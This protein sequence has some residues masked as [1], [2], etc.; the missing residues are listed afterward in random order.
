MS[1]PADDPRMALARTAMVEEQIAARGVRDPR[2]L[3]ALRQV[4][5][6]RF[7]PGELLLQA[8]GDYPLPIGRGQTISQP[9]I[10]AFMA[11]ALALKGHERVLE[12]GSG[13]G[14]MTAVLSRLCREVHGIELE[15]EL[16]EASRLRLDDLGCEN[17]QLHAG[18][19]A[20]GWPPA[21]PFDAIL[22]SC[23]TPEIPAPLWEQ[24]AEGGSLLLPL[25]S[26]WSFQHLVL[27]RKLTS[28]ATRRVLLAVSF[29]PLRSL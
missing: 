28:G 9:Y 10:V 23:A 2:V 3:E 6:H 18:D 4:P 25:G 1:Y 22:L 14:Y 7:V 5:R 17:V 20:G 15:E 16:L 12:V 26:P 24:L 13:S 19:G 27:D 29:V 11:E 8:H 21:A